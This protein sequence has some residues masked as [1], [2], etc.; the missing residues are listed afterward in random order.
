[1]KIDASVIFPLFL[2]TACGPNYG[3]MHSVSKPLHVDVIHNHNDRTTHRA[4]YRTAIE[5]SVIGLKS[6]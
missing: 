2:W 4:G 5:K 3:F 1:M 6:G